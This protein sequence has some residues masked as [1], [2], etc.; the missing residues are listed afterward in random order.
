MG[1]VN[2]RLIDFGLAQY[3]PECDRSPPQKQDGKRVAGTLNW[4][5]TYLHEGFG[6]CFAIECR[7]SMSS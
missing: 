6:M 4:C 7:I 1:K 5:S 3:L 2:V